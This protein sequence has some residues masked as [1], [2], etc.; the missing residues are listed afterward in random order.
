MVFISSPDDTNISLDPL[1]YD[2]GLYAYTMKIW[3]GVYSHLRFA[4]VGRQD[5]TNFST[6][7]KDRGIP[8]PEGVI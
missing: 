8:N 5:D 3:F 4:T 1:R 6:I 7:K 2:A